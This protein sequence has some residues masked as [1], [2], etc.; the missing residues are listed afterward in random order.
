MKAPKAPAA[1]DPAT[2]A[3]AQ[4]ASNV[5]TGVSNSYLGNANERSTLGNVDYKITGHH[6]VGG[7]DV[8][9]FTKTTTLSP[10]QQRLYDQQNNIGFQENGIATKELGQ[11][12][13]SLSKPLNYDGLP[14]APAYDRGHYEDALNARLEPQL[15]RDRAALE[16]QLANQGVR[17]GSEAYREAI[18]LSDRG[19]NDARTNSVLSAGGY[20]DQEQ[21]QGYQAR[22]HAIQER[23]ALRSQPIN[24]I[25][26][27]MNGG[28]VTMP[29]FSQ[30]RG[31]NVAETDTAGI[32]QQGFQNQMGIYNQKNANRNAMFGGIAGLAGS[33]LGGPIGGALAKGMFGGIGGGGGSTGGSSVT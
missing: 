2:V 23:T 7:Q 13:D 15:Q 17:S 29:Q 8:P 24:E 10:T 14:Q 4:T 30:Y 12:N 3:A 21:A 5:N 18:A 11:L 27:L 1:P 19:R 9:T 26:T 25:S 20:A 31:G 33:V 28:Q 32:T 22:D 16:N 6:T